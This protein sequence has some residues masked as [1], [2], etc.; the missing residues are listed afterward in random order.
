MY[1][2][3]EILSFADSIAH[4]FRVVF[5]FTPK[6]SELPAVK[7]ALQTFGIDYPVFLTDHVEFI[8]LNP[9]LPEHDPRMHTFLLDADNKVLLAG[10]PVNNEKLWEL[11]K[12]VIN[13]LMNNNGRLP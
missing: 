6:E 10:N 2:W 8:K 4:R 3:K 7:T 12:P 5:L 11:Y 1:E 9:S 13:K